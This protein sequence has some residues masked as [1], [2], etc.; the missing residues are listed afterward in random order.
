MSD[1]DRYQKLK[2]RERVCREKISFAEGKYGE[3]KA[4]LVALVNKAIENKWVDAGEKKPSQAIKKLIER[5][6]ADSDRITA[7]VE[8]IL[9]DVEGDCNDD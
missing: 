6:I 1:V 8:S 5:N 7:E 9:V 3:I 4:G 2:E